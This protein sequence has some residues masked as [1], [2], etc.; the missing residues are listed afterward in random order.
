MAKNYSLT[1]VVQIIVENEDA[2]QLVEIGKRFPLL[3]AKITRIAVKAGEDL[4]DLMQFMPGSLTAN[5]VNQSIKKS[6]EGEEDEVEDVEDEDFEDAET[7]EVTSKKSGKGK[8][9][10]VKGKKVENKNE[11]DGGVNTDF[12]SMNTT[13]MYKLLGEI[14]KRKDCKEK[15]GDFSKASMLK[16]LKK[17]VAATEK[18]ED[19][20][21]EGDV[22][23]T[24]VYEN[25]K[26]VDLYKLCKERK[27]KAEKQKPAKYYVQLLK[28]ADEEAAKVED[29]AEDEDWDEEDEEVEEVPAKKPEKN[30]KATSK[31]KNKPV[32][33]EEDEDWDI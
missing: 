25:M 12:D 1:E 22:E 20:E 13:Q 9:A 26:A 10:P 24:P 4:N 19:D 3:A 2:A 30:T 15:F 18:T 16:Y 8:G 33:E 11:E 17:Y 6:L 21:A 23:G 27:I 5:K 28:K 31:G 14:G 29:E 7:E 32:K